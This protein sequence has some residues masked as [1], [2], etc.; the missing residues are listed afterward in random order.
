[1]NIKLP[2]PPFYDIWELCAHWGL[3]NDGIDLIC[4]YV[5]IGKLQMVYRCRDTID[6]LN[7]EP[8][9]PSMIEAVEDLCGKTDFFFLRTEVERFEREECG[10]SV[11]APVLTGIPEPI[12]AGINAALDVHTYLE[13][14]MN[15]PLKEKVR[16]LRE[17]YRMENEIIADILNIGTKNPRS[18]SRK[19]KA[20]Q[21]YRSN[22]DDE[23]WGKMQAAKKRN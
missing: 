20:Q 9:V 13:Q 15:L 12:P 8:V 16:H 17:N 23:T 2:P 22:F 14:N 10:L 4:K 18:K 7:W 5:Q 19:N 6:Y 1:M 21:L 11:N 3:Q